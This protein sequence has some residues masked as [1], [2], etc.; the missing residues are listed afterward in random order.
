M[1]DEDESDENS[2]PPASPGDDPATT[3]GQNGVEDLAGDRSAD[4]DTTDKAAVP[5]PPGGEKAGEHPSEGLQI[6]GTVTAVDR[7]PERTIP[8][9]YPV[10]ISTQ[11]A[12]AIEL[13]IGG[14]EDVHVVIYF[15]SPLRGVDERLS[16]LLTLTEGSPTDAD[17]LESKSLLLT[18]QDG[19]YMPVVP[20]EPPRGS[21]KAVY[22]IF[23]GLLPSILIAL[24]GI[25]SPGAGVITTT[26]F[27]LS[28]FL[29]TFLVLPASMY[30]DALNLR[31]TTN[32]EGT[33]RRWAILAAI[34]AFNVVVIPLYL[35]GRENAEPLA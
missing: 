4:G 15:E 17:D 12:V 9:N 32:W 22:G 13:S 18:V 20:A 26:P 28:W 7:V 25:F 11:K 30:V 33:P 6:R 14:P 29:G 16:R 21:G 19:F 2:K 5:A 27:V 23:L 3:G 35:I 8:S 24:V 1:V 31:S 34:P 10:D